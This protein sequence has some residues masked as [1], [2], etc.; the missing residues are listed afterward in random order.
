M[1]MLAIESRGTAWDL[2][3]FGVFGPDLPFIDE[4]LAFTFDR[5]LIDRDRLCLMG[6]SD[7]ASYAL[8]LGTSNG[9]LF[10]HLLSFSPG[11][12]RIAQP[13][14]GK[15]LIFISHGTEDQIL[16]LQATRDGIVPDLRSQ[17]YD[18]TYEE[19]VGPH[20]VPREIAQAAF[21][22]FLD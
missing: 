3:Q 13:Q 2:I 8:S 6:F 22:W 21:D 4:A 17:G 18:V 19:F 7:G 1:I 20:I 15:P 14:V 10:T 12:W 9:D 16:P 11:F 5:C